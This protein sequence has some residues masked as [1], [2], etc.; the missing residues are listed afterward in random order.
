M[1]STRI[2]GSLLFISLLGL[3]SPIV[4]AEETRPPEGG[5]VPIYQQILDSLRESDSVLPMVPEVHPVVTLSNGEAVVPPQCYTR[6]EI[7][8]NP[9]YVCH[10]DPIDGRENV[11]ADADLQ[12]AYSFSDMGMTNHWKNLFE[13]RTARAAAI[14]DE[15]ILRYIGED[16]YSELSSRLREKD[17]KGWI[18]DLQNLHLGKDAFDVQG[19]AKDGSDWVAFNYK[20]FPSTFWPTNGSTDDVMIRLHLRF[21]TDR[22]GKKSAE[23]Y[24]ANLAILEANIKGVKEIGSLPVD[25][26][27]VGKDLDG[28]G[29]LEVVTRITRTGSWVGAAEAEP[30]DT[31]LYPQGTEFLHT[32]RYVGI[33]KDGSIVSSTR[34]KEVRYSKK[35]KSFSKAMYARRYD[36]EAMEKE[37]GNLPAYHELGQLGID[38]GNGWALQG[39][40][41]D[42]KG[43]LR[44]YT[45]EENFSCMGCHNTIGSTID[46]TFS[47]P[48]KLDGTKG[49]GYLDLKGM[50]DAPNKGETLGEIVTYLAR[51]GGG[52]EFRNNDEMSARWL[53]EDGTTDPGK[54]AEAKDVYDLITPSRERALALNKAYR[55]IVEDQD[56]IYGKDAV[57]TPPKN[58]YDKIDNETSPTLPID[59]IYK[60]NILLDWPDQAATK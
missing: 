23:I 47:F 9:C 16:N 18:P 19:F 10:Q 48:R 29:S 44:A 6:T 15:E 3:A 51:A 26:N 57:L 41:E 17:F 28:N 32:V 58:V 34:M 55:T 4:N 38:N 20:P 5:G 33:G 54:L 60:W 8:H 21:R 53:K 31:S 11:M 27:L 22:E 13:D 36:L 52:S 37:A 43:R 50:P 46:K 56:F 59:K 14:S 42:K 49:W 7:R 2:P 24:K 35:A 25:E 1:N 30:L 45:Y 40:I 12:E 39:F